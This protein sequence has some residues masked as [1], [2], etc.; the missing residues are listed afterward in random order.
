M[1]KKKIPSACIVVDAS[2]ARSAGPPE[3]NDERSVACRAFLMALRGVGHR[4]AWNAPIKAEWD[5]HQSHFAREWWTAMVS[6]GNVFPVPFVLSLELRQAI[7]DAGVDEG[8]KQAMTKDLHLV[9]TAFA[10][11]HRVG[12][13]DDKVRGHFARFVAHFESLGVVLWVNPEDADEVATEWVLAGA[14]NKPR[15]RLEKYRPA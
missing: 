10:S 8:V 4:V 14:P 9:E 6:I 5:K 11:N 2:I 12:S 3:S 7:E 13:L 15:H 1:S